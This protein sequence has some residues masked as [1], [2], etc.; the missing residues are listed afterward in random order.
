M[1][2]LVAELDLERSVADRSA[3]VTLPLQDLFDWV[4]VGMALFAIAEV[5]KRG[6]TIRTELD[7]LI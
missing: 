3:S 5:V 2:E 7:T 4:L 1:L 6:V